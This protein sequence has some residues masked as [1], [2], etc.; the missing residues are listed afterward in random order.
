MIFSRL[1]TIAILTA[2]ATSGCVDRTP[3]PASTQADSAAA[4][5]AATTSTASGELLELMMGTGES[6]AFPLATGSFVTGSLN[7]PKAGKVSAFAIQI[8][9]YANTADGNVSIELCQHG[10]CSSG[11]QS[12]AG[13]KDNEYLEIA[14][15]RPL[16]VGTDSPLTYRFTKLD[17]GNQVALWLYEPT[18]VLSAMKINDQTAVERAPKIALRF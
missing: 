11:Q 2:L 7:L 6:D 12:L 4:S 1:T 14:M 10:R 15:E 5:A 13:S 17:G 9:N 16:D 18:E 3:V 8:G